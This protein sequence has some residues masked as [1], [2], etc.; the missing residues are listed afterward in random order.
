MQLSDADLVAFRNR[1]L[2]AQQRGYAV[3]RANEY[4]KAL[5]KEAGLDL[6]SGPVSVGDLVDLASALLKVRSEGGPKRMVPRDP[7]KAA[8]APP[9]APEP[10]PESSVPS[11]LEDVKPASE[12]EH[13]EIE[14]LAAEADPELETPDYA[15]WTQKALAKEAAARNL[16]GRSSMGK[17]ELVVALQ[18][19]DEGNEDEGE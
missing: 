3:A 17:E 7:P 6:S 10:K 11:V 12:E 4:A 1:C 8:P 14:R 18:K 19:H 13:A 5:S 15:T 9:K 16:S 2:T